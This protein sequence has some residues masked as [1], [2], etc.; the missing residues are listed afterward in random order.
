V[1]VRM[2][3][4]NDYRSGARHARFERR[5]SGWI[6]RFDCIDARKRMR[7]GMRYVLRCR[8]FLP[9]LQNSV[10]VA[11]SQH[12]SLALDDAHIPDRLGFRAC[13][14]TLRPDTRLRPAM[15]WV[16]CIKRS[17]LRATCVCAATW[18]RL[19]F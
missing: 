4:G 8:T 10:A 19:F 7:N 6:V 18:S 16:R 17:N 9:V 12:Q 15:T 11:V 3:Y 1:T 14:H 2:P 5:M 13:R